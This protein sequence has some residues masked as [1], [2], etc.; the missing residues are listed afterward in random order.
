MLCG[1]ARRA[2]YL[3]TEAFGKG[4]C[5]GEMPN[6]HVGRSRS[7]V[8]GDKDIDSGLLDIIFSFTLMDTL[9][10]CKKVLSQK[11]KYEG[12]HLG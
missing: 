3:G 10:S 9:Y 8:Q 4:I 5:V 7:C 6:K 1:R 12:I 11:Y 2:R